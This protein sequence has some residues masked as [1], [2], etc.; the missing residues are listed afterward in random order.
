MKK[1]LSLLLLIISLISFSWLFVST[2]TAGSHAVMKHFWEPEK[3]LK[4]ILDVIFSERYVAYSAEKEISSFNI[5]ARID[6]WSK[7]KE[8]KHLHLNR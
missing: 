5:L 7:L 2:S 4:G 3:E 1:L 6:F 8:E